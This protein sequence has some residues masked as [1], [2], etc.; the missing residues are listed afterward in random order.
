MVW[1]LTLTRSYL[2]RTH[3][4]KH[5]EYLDEKE[6]FHRKNNL[7]ISLFDKLC[8]MSSGHWHSSDANGWVGMYNCSVWHKHQFMRQTKSMLNSAHLG[9]PL[10]SLSDIPRMKQVLPGNDHFRHVCRPTCAQGVCIYH[11]ETCG[12]P[13]KIYRSQMFKIR[14]FQILEYTLYSSRMYVLSTIY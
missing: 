10:K 5:K 8:L 4:L 7:C 1:P 2:A 9:E 6:I 13:Y 12:S 11:C 14:L 3:G